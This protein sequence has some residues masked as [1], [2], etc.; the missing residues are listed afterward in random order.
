MIRN[1]KTEDIEDI[2]RIEQELFLDDAWDADTFNNEISSNPFAYLFVYEINDQIAGYVDLWIS[3]ENAEIADIAVTSSYQHQH[4]GSALMDYCVQKCLESNCM[5]LSLEVRI[6][7]QNAI[8]LYE[9]KGF[10]KVTKRRHYYSD[11]EDAWLMVKEL[12][13]SAYDNAAGN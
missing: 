4:I 1:L 8:A 7:N 3:Y 11:G 6:S 2:C 13:G 5:N 12:G 10:T 9:K